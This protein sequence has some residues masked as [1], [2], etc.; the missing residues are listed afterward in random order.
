MSAQR[1]HNQKS[2][3][4]IRRNL[5][6]SLTPAEASLWKALQGSKL[7]GKKFRR[8]H[9]IGNYVVDFYCPE[10]KLAIELDG[11]KHFNT[12]ASEYDLR[13]TEFLSRNNIR[14]LRF[15]NRAVFEHPEGVLQAIKDHLSKP[16]TTP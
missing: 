16:A 2:M 11:E 14:V 10:C 9:S 12:I 13:R 1:I 7:A 8:Q 4:E 3:K 5:R 6:H 15:E